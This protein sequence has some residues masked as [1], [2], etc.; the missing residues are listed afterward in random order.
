MEQNIDIL[1]AS[2]VAYINVDCAVAGP[3]FNARASPQLDD[4]IME[5]TKQVTDPDDVDQSLYKSW[6]LSSNKTTPSIG[7]LGGGDSDYASFLQ[8]AGVPSV[9]LF[10]SEDYPVYHSVYDNYNWMSKFGDPLFRRHVAVTSVWGSLALRLANDDILPMKY[11]SYANELHSYALSI[12]S[13][14]SV[15]NAPGSISC[16]PLLS[17]IEDLQTSIRQFTEELM[18]V[19]KEKVELQSGLP[20][21]LLYHRREV[22]DRLLRA[23]RAFLDSDGIQGSFA[24]KHLVYGPVAHNA[25]GSLSFPGIW[26]SIYE[27]ATNSNNALNSTKW[28]AVQHEIYRGA[29]VTTRAALVLRGKLT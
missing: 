11:E 23:E 13:R 19:T 2:A 8:H 22:N 17:A 20:W 16:A 18:A 12:V 14:L 3:G 10:F 9:D 29:R 24:F 1:G 21:R 25:Y 5:V 28:A 7:R 26:G 4:L 27:A 6:V 15:V